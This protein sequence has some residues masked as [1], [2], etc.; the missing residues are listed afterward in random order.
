[1]PA[2]DVTK[3]CERIREQ[4]EEFD[5]PPLRC[6]FTHEHEWPCSFET[7]AQDMA[8][9][10]RERDRLLTEHANIR[11]RLYEIDAPAKRKGFGL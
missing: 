5:R 9:L 7:D 11:R 3:Q 1:M 2:T 10:C 8:M 4:P 6:T